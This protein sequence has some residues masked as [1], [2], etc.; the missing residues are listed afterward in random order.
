MNIKKVAVI[1]GGTMGSGIAH[2]FAQSGF[3]VT[4]IEASREIAAKALASI[5][6]N[7]DRQVKKGVLTA[8]G[9]AAGLGR[10][11][12]A[13]ELEAAAP[14]EL[15]VEAVPEALALK[16]DVFSRLDELLGPGAILASNTS[17]LPITT[18]AAATKRPDRVIGM[19]F[20]NPVP[21]MKL[22]ELIRG[23]A[24]S[25]ETYETVRALTQALGKTPVCSR[26]FPGFLSNRI[27][28]P[29]INEAAY[30]LLEGVGSREDIDATLKLGMGHPMGPLT[31]AD[32]IGIDVCVAILDV[33]CQGF[34]DPKYRCCPLLRQMAQAGRLGRKTGRGFYD[35]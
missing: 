6:A 5:A 9:K 23:L 24:T 12:T 15:A 35:Y 28:M 31:L 7:M 2:A 29:L 13:L 1:G 20:M 17:S 8:E 26:D 30:C 11:V 14:A 10:I 32:F 25:D 18:I 19:H 34:G 33:L 27:L 21:V 16:K 22:V 3:S 4:L